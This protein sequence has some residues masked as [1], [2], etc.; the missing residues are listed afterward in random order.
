MAKGVGCT[1][2]FGSGRG[3]WGSRATGTAGCEEACRI[4]TATEADE[5]VDGSDT[6]V[7]GIRTSGLCTGAGGTEEAGGGLGMTVTETRPS[8][9]RN[10]WGSGATGTAGSNGDGVCGITIATGAGEIGDGSGTAVDGL[11]GSS[12]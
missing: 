5:I 10:G 7:D 1:L 4:A 12:F 6:D 2:G 8:G 11:S 3:G 9:D